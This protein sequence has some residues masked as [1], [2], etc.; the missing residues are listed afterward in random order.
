MLRRKKAYK[1]P[2]SILPGIHR[3]SC[4]YGTCGFGGATARCSQ[5]SKLETPILFWGPDP[6]QGLH[7][8]E[9]KAIL[10]LP[11]LAR[12]SHNDIFHELSF[13]PCSTILPY[14]GDAAEG[15]EL[16]ARGEGCLVSSAY[17]NNRKWLREMCFSAAVWNGRLQLCSKKAL[18]VRFHLDGVAQSATWWPWPSGR[19]RRP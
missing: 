5:D 14:S 4:S 8:P 2:S 13:C 11:L 16:I 17:S 12:D 1:T 6:I 19:W 3:K 18:T 9:E 10:S 7:A 15:V